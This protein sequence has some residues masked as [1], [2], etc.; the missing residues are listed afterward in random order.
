MFWAFV[1]YAKEQDERGEDYSLL[2]LYINLGFDWNA[3][4]NPITAQTF[5]F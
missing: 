5:P 4:L 2:Q 1:K 3:N